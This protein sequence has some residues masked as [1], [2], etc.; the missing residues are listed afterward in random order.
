MSPAG[1][2]L[3]AALIY[4]AIR[5]GELY[6]FKA[7]DPLHVVRSTLRRHCSDHHFPSARKNKYSRRFDDDRY[8]LLPE[9]ECVEPNVY[10]VVSDGRRK[11]ERVVTVP[12]EDRE[13]STTSES[14]STHTD[15]QWILLDLGRK[16]GLSVWAP[17]ADRSH[18]C[19]R[20]RIGDILELVD[21][22]PGQFSKA[23]LRTVRYIDVMWIRKQAVVGAFEIEHTSTIY[24]GLLRMSDML[25]MHPSS[26]IHWYIVAPDQRYDKFAN[27][28]ARPTF[29]YLEPPLHTVCGFLPYSRLLEAVESAAQFAEYLSPEFIEKFAERFDPEESFE[30]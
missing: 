16:M 21:K 10:R 26:P 4:E 17:I 20:G 12:P 8:D 30:D 3:T 19:D 29:R 2:P 9:P 15:I 7:K 6:D 1:E 27:E 23:A 22:L 13:S 28:V 24:S 25:T 14:G 18:C 11:Q 5:D